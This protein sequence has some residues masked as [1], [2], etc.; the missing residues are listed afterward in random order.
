[1]GGDSAAANPG[2]EYADLRRGQFLIARRHFSR[3]DPIEQV[4]AF[5]VAWRNRGARLP[6]FDHQATEP[7]IQPAL[8]DVLASVTVQTMGAENRPDI[9]LKTRGT[10]RFL[11]RTERFRLAAETGQQEN[12]NP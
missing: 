10:G 8:A 4:T 12:G 6:P 5:G 9:P 1:M 7:H 11:L 3:F 2:F